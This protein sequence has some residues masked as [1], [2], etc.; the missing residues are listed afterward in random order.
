M[1]TY[2]EIFLGFMVTDKGIEANLD[3]TKDIV[4]LKE[5]KTIQGIE[6]LT[7][8]M[9]TLSRFIVISVKSSLPFFKVL[10]GDESI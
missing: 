8:M 5:H 9:V 7:K 10:K 3:K 2:L 4:D 1:G 6:K